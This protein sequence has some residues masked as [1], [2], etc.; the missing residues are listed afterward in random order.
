M[1][2]FIMVLSVLISGA[3]LTVSAF[4]GN[5]YQ[6]S[7]AYVFLGFIVF[8]GMIAIVLYRSTDKTFIDMQ[9]NELLVIG[10][11]LALI[12]GSGTALLLVTY[13]VFTG[14]LP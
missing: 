7:S 11:N 12:G 2:I 1:K 4:V 9:S 10:R 3:L 13:Y 8:L 6:V 5:R 14:T